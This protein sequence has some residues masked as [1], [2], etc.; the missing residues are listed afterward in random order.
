[1]STNGKTTVG[2]IFGG[3]TVEHDV[4]IVTGHQVMRALLA[5]HAKYDV[6]PIYIDRKGGWFTGAP[7]MD[8]KNYTEHLTDLMGV[9]EV[10]L[11][12]STKHR[13]V[14]VNPGSG[15]LRRSQ[16]IELDVMFPTI[17]GSHGEDG[18]LQGLFELA[19]IPYVGCGVMASAIA[20]DKIMSK[21]VLKQFQ[22]PVIDAVSFSREEWQHDSD[23]VMQQATLHLNY[24][25]FIKP[26]TLG[27]SIGIGKATDDKSLR[28]AIE[29]ALNFDRR[30][31]IE[32]SAEGAIE[33]NC[34]VIGSGYEVRASILEKPTSF[35][36]FLD[37]TDKYLQGAGGMKGAERTI[38]A[39]IS[40]E[41]TE[42][43]KA[44]A[45][46][47][48]QAIEGSGIARMDFLVMEDTAEFYL[49][50]INTMPGSLAF[51]LW[52]EEG[53]GAPAVVD[54]LIQLA[55]QTSEA[56]R[57]NMYDYQTSLVELTAERGLKGVKGSKNKLGY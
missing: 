3:R 16:V 57:R 37:F 18:T 32:K 56:K 31:L 30:V 43:I 19:N 40:N 47:A 13:G 21:V 51:Y 49:N 33:V 29:V 25:L 45:I 26:A 38:P 8:L 17:H 39:P 20:N 42:A 27:S 12:P 2:V 46:N 53:M 41:L 55:K 1:M 44:T 24:P 54:E 34:A 50:E 35:S 48:F 22:I 23:K 28:A 5:N 7:L 9:Q 52:Q 4:S 6:L 36:E 15:F 14:I 11:S 10:S